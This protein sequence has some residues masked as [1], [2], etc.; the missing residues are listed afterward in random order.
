ME[1]K[2][3]PKEWINYFFLLSFLQ[4]LFSCN[5]DNKVNENA[6]NIILIMAD[7]WSY[8]HAGFYGD[9]S[10]KTPTMD[11]LAK[12]GV[13][14]EQAFVSAPSCTPSRAAILS[15]QH[16]WRLGQ[17]ANL[18]GKLSAE[19]PIYTEIMRDAGY[20]VGYTDKGWGPGKH[21]HLSSNPAGK[22]FKSFKNFV[23]KI[24]P[25]QPFCF[26][27]GSYNPH[28]GYEGGSA[29]EKG[30]DI[31]KIQMPKVYPESEVI[32][33]DMADY[34]KEVQDLDEEVNQLINSL[35]NEGVLDN[36]IIIITSDN[37]MPFPRA[38]GNL[39]DL[40]TRVPLIT[41]SGR[42]VKQKGIRINQL[43]SLTD[44]APTF[45]A[46]AGLEIPKV[47]TGR[48]L[49]KLLEDSSYKLREEVFFGRERHV[50]GQENGDWGGYPMRAVRTQKY[51]LIKNF[52]PDRWPAGT[53]NYYEA[54]FFPSYYSDVDG[55]PT[56]SYLIDHRHDDAEYQRLFEESFGKRPAFELY[57]V[58]KD[59]DQLENIF[60][61]PK[62]SVIKTHLRNLLNSELIKTKDPR[63]IANG[64][65]FEK[66]NYDGGAPFPPNFIRQ[67]NRYA[68]LRIDSFP[69]KW[70]IP[71]P[72]EVLFPVNVSYGER[73]PVIYMHDGQNIFHPNNAG[74]G[75]KGLERG[76]DVD[77]I[78]DSLN[79]TGFDQ[80][81]IIVGIFNTGVRRRAEYMP[82]EPREEVFRRLDLLEDKYFS[83]IPLHSDNYLEFLV[84]EL[85]PYVDAH[86]KTLADR[87]HTFI[88]GSSMGGMISA[89]AI[90]K[91]PEIYGGAACLSTHWVPL[92]GV[93]VDYFEKNL[94]D[95]ITHKLYFDF[96]TRGLD[97]RYEPYQNEIDQAMHRKGYKKGINWIT[98]KV[99]E[100]DHNEAAWHQRFHEPLIFLLSNN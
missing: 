94:P 26:W 23:Q 95:P 51:L 77:F 72:I 92:E 41:W 91:Y 65:I 61:D 73:F 34:L 29:R 19:V 50:P 45:L 100:A 30:L 25:A 53:P 15:G 24:D 27:F 22:Y 67:G 54:S 99:F 64:E 82:E 60:D 87:E 71:R 97:A 52:S 21:D 11:R 12:E 69:S 80:K 78:L 8:P 43:V 49:V 31:S 55:G 16:F 20:A 36:T 2:M 59:P 35:K 17:G 81:A 88:A 9:S 6:P 1:L 89:Y 62:F 13:I 42:E 96:G 79:E 38:K 37:G 58:K 57:D 47:M 7:D 4:A 32:R 18:F 40:G 98:K 46:W 33:S 86:F 70:V 74:F 63:Q 93:F 84:K 48:S 5:S 56:K 75:K 44:L 68:T 10:V 90:S 3:K 76:W 83:D 28:R 85:K 66:N 39:Y 14:F